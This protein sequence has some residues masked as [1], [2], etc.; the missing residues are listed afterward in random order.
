MGA[1]VM[2]RGCSTLTQEAVFALAEIVESVASSNTVDDSVDTPE[3]TLVRADAKLVEFVIIQHLHSSAR[4]QT[5][6]R[7]PVRLEQRSVTNTGLGLQ[8]Q[9]PQC[10]RG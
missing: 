8:T 10:N 3:L 7:Q 1:R 9:H 2:I 4:R 6:D 5:A